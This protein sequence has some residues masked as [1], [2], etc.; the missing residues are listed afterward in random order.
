MST[1]YLLRIKDFGDT[2]SHAVVELRKPEKPPAACF[3][4]NASRPDSK[5]TENERYLSLV[6]GLAVR[7][8]AEIKKGSLNGIFPTLRDVFEDLVSD[9]ESGKNIPVSRFFAE[10]FLTHEK[11]YLKLF[12]E[13]QFHQR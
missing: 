7:K 3:Y 6:Y 2:M 12:R 11:L 8:H 9:L 4:Q 13:S 10:T 5:A 1:E